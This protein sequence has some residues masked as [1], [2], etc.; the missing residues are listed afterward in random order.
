MLALF[1]WKYVLMRYIFWKPI[2]RLKELSNTWKIISIHWHYYQYS[3]K[4]WENQEK[5]LNKHEIMPFQKIY[6]ESKFL[7]NKIQSTHVMTKCYFKRWFPKMRKR[8][9]SFCLC[10]RRL[11][12]CQSFLV[13]VLSSYLA[14]HLSVFK[15]FAIF[16]L[17]FTISAV[18][19]TFDE[20][21]Y[22]I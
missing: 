19:Y 15:C 3:F 17:N 9:F 11:F 5:L 7:K 14:Y 2:E 22:E 16:F 13:I 20:L 1:F 4:L 8:K 10:Q 21:A 6:I 18:A 12:K